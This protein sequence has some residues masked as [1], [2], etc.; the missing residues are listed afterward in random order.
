[1]VWRICIIRTDFTI[2]RKKID[3]AE[4]PAEVEQIKQLCEKYQVPFVI[5]DDLKLAA[6]F[7]LGVDLGQSDGEI[8]DAKSQLPEGVIIGRTCLITSIP[9][10]PASGLVAVAEQIGRHP[11]EIHPEI[12][13]RN[14][15]L[16][17]SG[18]NYLVELWRANGAS[19]TVDE[20]M[21]TPTLQHI[22]QLL[23]L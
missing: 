11:M 16:D 17:A 5:N 8:T 3:K 2:C 13:L 20:L 10:L 19:L 14:Y 4:Q 18:V 22:M 7:G 12:D 21:Q 6:Q 1:M 9:T 23:K 15:G